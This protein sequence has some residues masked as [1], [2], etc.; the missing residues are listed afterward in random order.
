MPDKEITCPDCGRVL[1]VRDEGGSV[2][3][4]YSKS[5]WQRHAFAPKV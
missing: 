2:T 5:G 1:R 4:S 3:L